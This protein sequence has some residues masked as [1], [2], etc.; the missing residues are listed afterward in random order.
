MDNIIINDLYDLN[1]TIAAK[2]FEGHTYPWEVLPEI[3]DFIKE[4]GETLKRLLDDVL[5][6]PSCNTK[7]ILME[8]V[9]KGL[10]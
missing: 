4:L 9:L 2:L 10:D 7:E 1:E 5:E 6:D 3:S 8:K